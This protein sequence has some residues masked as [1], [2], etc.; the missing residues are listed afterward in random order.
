VTPG[1][2]WE[3]VANFLKAYWVLKL[4]RAGV[5]VRFLTIFLLE[6]PSS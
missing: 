5:E 2:G 3:P 4:S 1:G 6:R